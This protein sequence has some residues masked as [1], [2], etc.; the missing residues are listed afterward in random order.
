[1]PVRCAIALTL[2]VTALSSFLVLA[3]VSYVFLTGQFK[4]SFPKTFDILL[5]GL[6]GFLAGFL[7]SSFL[8]LA[9]TMTPLSRNNIVSTI[10][11]NRLSQQ[12]G[13]SYVCWW[14]DV[15]NSIVSTPDN[16]R[17]SI[18]IVNHLLSSAESGTQD[19]TNQETRPNKLA[20]P[21]RPEANP[22]QQDDAA[23]P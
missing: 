13:I 10:G 16:R 23:R 7:V 20:E 15:L 4:V 12:P 6:L 8:S 14:C 2:A 18:Q 21:G 5:A 22:N 1:M 9:I 19:T 11:F 3:G 17:T